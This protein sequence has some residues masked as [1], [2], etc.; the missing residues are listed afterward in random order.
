M[1]GARGTIA[2]ALLVA[3]GAAWLVYEGAPPDDP[4]ASAGTLLGEPR[5]IDPNNP[6]AR[7]VNFIPAD[8]QMV[9]LV[10]GG[11][12]LIT[13]RIGTIWSG[14]PTPNLIPDFLDSLAQLG[15]LMCL[16]AGPAQLHEYGLDSPQGEIELRPITG[17]PVLVLLGDRNP[18][19]TGAY[20][21]IG[22]SGDVVLAG[23]LILWEFDKAFKALGGS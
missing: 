20:V 19:A 1:M 15:E 12:R 18:P 8:I 22:R 13:T 11:K 14:A 10:R 4:R 2:L 6:T 3:L 16:E 7:L 5:E 21:R 23:A 9:T 17:E